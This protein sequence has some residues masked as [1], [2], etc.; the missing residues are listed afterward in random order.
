MA[1]VSQFA[2]PSGPAR[3]HS[4]L[5]VRHHPAGPPRSHRKWR[6]FRI[7][8]PPGTARPHAHLRMTP[9]RW[10]PQGPTNV[11]TVSQFAAHRDGEASF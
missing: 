2:A 9:L 11:A 6:Q 3:S 8:Q 10:T 4:D 1:T 7:S 5:R